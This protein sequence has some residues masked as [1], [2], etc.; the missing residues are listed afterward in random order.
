MLL[1]ITPIGGPLHCYAIFKHMKINSIS[2]NTLAFL[3]GYNGIIIPSGEVGMSGSPRKMQYKFAG[4]MHNIP[5]QFLNEIPPRDKHERNKINIYHF[6]FFQSQ[7]ESVRPDLTLFP[8]YLFI[9]FKRFS[10]RVL[11]VFFPFNIEGRYFLIDFFPFGKSPISA[12]TECNKIVDKNN[13]YYYC[14]V[15][16]FFLFVCFLVLVRK[17][18]CKG[19]AN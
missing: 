12:C 6:F 8:C 17:Y 19:T 14:Q 11:Y 13:H 9:L 5:C 1:Q 2:P 4:S 7:G 18:T 3:G 15:Q 10:R 16:L